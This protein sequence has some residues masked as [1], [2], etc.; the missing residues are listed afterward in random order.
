MMKVE[1]LKYEDLTKEEQENQPNNGIGKEYA[2]YIK[3]SHE[4]V[5][6]A[7]FVL[8]DAV[9]PED[10]TFRRDFSGVAYA[11]KQ[12]YEIGKMDGLYTK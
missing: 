1:L 4:K 12:A 7:V 3:V 5:E 9:E 2:N 11:I 6:G 8:S 10:A